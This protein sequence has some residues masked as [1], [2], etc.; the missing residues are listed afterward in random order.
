LFIHRFAAPL[1]DHM[2]VVPKDEKNWFTDFS[3][4]SKNTV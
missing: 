4:L 2:M 1:L 3:L